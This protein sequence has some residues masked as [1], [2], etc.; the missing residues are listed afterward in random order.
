LR[1]LVSGAGL[2]WIAAWIGFSR[3]AL[4][5]DALIHLRYAQTSLRAGFMT[6]DGMTFSYG[7]SSPLYVGL[8]AVL[9]AATASALL[10]KVVSVVFYLALLLLVAGFA[11]EGR[12]GRAGW[13]L[14]GLLLLSPMAIRWLTDGMETSLAALFAVL[15]ATQTVAGG[16]RGR[17][18]VPWLCFTLGAA[19]VLTRIELSLAIFFALAGALPLVPPSLWARR[20]LPLALGGIGS[21]AA[22]QILFGHVLPDTAMAKRTAP[23]SFWEAL[24]QVERSTLSSLTLGAGLSILWLLSLL[25]GLRTADRRGRIALLTCNLLFPSLVA[26]I[27]IRGQILHG[28]RYL[29]WVYLFLIAWNLCA[30]A[31]FPGRAELW[32]RGLRLWIVAGVLLVLWIFEGRAV[33]R[34]LEARNEMFLAMRSDALHRLSGATGAGFDVGFIGFFSQARILDLNGLVNGRAVAKLKPEQRLRRLSAANPDFL[35]VTGPQAKSLAPFLDVGAYRV[36]H[37]YRAATLTADQVYFLATRSDRTGIPPCAEKW[38]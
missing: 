26:L 13:I 14:L 30:Q 22:L 19:I 21:L 28:V 5:D 1:L 16:T 18:W 12:E 37:Q 27:A 33:A 8:L 34:V 2:L 7:T 3:Y 32:P 9:S 20:H 15:L 4:L 31:R 38:P 24:F 29:L 6:F 23:V 25:H 10:P 36:C 17:P 11:A 35:F